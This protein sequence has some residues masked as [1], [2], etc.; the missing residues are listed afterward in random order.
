MKLWHPLVMPSQDAV[1]I[2]PCLLIVQ[3]KT[4]DPWPLTT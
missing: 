3:V 4:R 2:Y 1:P